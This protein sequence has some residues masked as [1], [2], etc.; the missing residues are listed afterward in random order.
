MIQHETQQITLHYKKRVWQFPDEPFVEYEPSDERWCRFFGV[1]QEVEVTEV[2]TIP[3][4]YQ[5]GARM[6]DD[7]TIEMTFAS[8]G[9]D[10][11][12]KVTTL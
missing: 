6:R 8:I 4:C 11:E 12:V 10:V 9:T 7:G 3:N 5:N 1:G 2:V